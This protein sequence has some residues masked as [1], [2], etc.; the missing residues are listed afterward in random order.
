MP[1][2]NQM[3]LNTFSDYGRSTWLIQLKLKYILVSRMLALG[4]ITA[5]IYSVS[6][7]NGNNLK[8]LR[9]TSNLIITVKQI[10]FAWMPHK[11]GF[12]V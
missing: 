6:W 5:E 7:E 4:V 3:Y 8:K 11:T 9:A 1:N 12:V 2:S 10:T